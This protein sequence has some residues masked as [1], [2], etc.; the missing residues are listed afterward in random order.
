MFELLTTIMK[1]IMTSIRSSQF[2]ITK[3][4]I[5]DFN[6]VSGFLGEE[7]SLEDLEASIKMSRGPKGNVA[8][9]HF[10]VDSHSDSGMLAIKNLPCLPLWSLASDD[11]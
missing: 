4:Q 3:F 9:G 8:N 1:Q 6:E 2:S 11:D 7:Q 10:T 5:K